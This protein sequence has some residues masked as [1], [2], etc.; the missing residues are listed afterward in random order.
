MVDPSL[1]AFETRQKHKL[2]A[3]SADAR[4]LSSVHP[5]SRTKAARSRLKLGCCG[6]RDVASCAHVKLIQAVLMHTHTTFCAHPLCPPS[7]PTFFTY[8]S[9][10]A[11]SGKSFGLDEP[12]VCASV[13]RLSFDEAAL[14]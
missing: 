9:A 6:W 12:C 10:V 1:I 11:H 13:G 14:Q 2:D 5:C 4:V 7:V 8:G 3:H